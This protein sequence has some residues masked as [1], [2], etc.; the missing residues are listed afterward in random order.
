MAST[1]AVDGEPLR[2]VTVRVDTDGTIFAGGRMRTPG[3][4]WGGVPTLDGDGMLRTDDVGRISSGGILEVV[5]RNDDVFT[6]GG[7]NVS[8]E[9]VRMALVA[10]PAVASARVTAEPDDEYGA[11]PFARVV[12]EPGAATPPE[13]LI[14]HCRRLL[15]GPAVPRRIELRPRRSQVPGGR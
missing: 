7:E 15:P 14:A 8:T 6:C 1:V 13:D 3:Y 5:G 12:L 2:G 9:G 10:H 11:V 4:A